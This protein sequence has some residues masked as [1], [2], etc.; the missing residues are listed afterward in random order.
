VV[1]QGKGITL[2]GGNFAKAKNEREEEDRK[3]E[4]GVGASNFQLKNEKKPP[5]LILGKE[6]NKVIPEGKE[7]IRT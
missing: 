2:S 5:N 3:R 7:V 1:P 4:E 6:D